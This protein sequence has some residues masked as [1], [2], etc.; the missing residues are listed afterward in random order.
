MVVN[1]GISPCCKRALLLRAM[2]LFALMKRNPPI[3]FSLGDLTIP[4]KLSPS[5]ALFILASLALA[6]FRRR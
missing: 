2:P 6:F 5:E 4:T 1:W 3:D